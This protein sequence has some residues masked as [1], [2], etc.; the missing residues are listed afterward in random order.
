MSPVFQ[1][2]HTMGAKYAVKDVINHDNTIALLAPFA[3]LANV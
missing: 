3:A 2:S 1:W